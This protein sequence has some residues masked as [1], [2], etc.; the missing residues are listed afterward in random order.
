MPLKLMQINLGRCWDALHLLGKSMEDEGVDIVIVSEPR[1]VPNTSRW[2][3][4]INGLAAVHWATA[5]FNVCKLISRGRKY[6]IVQL[7]GIAGSVK[8]VSCYLAPSM[9]RREVQECLDAMR[10]N[11]KSL[12]ENVIVGGDFNA[13][14]PI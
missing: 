10:E 5:R 9:T 11:I 1:V 8:V 2:I 14:P 3:G 6:V 13:K 7:S 4:S 12:G